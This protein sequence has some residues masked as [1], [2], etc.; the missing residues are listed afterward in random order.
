MTNWKE[1]LAQKDSLSFREVIE[2]GLK[3]EEEGEEFWQNLADQLGKIG[4]EKDAQQ[5]MD[6]ARQEAAHRAFLKNLNLA[7]VA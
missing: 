2:A 7:L 1:R 6:F 5:A 4:W 3:D